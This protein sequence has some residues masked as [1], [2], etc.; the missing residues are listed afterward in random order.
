[1]KSGGFDE[2][3]HFFNVKKLHPHSHL[4]TSN[5]LIN[6]CGRVFE[7]Q[8]FFPLTKKN[9]ATLDFQKPILR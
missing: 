1:M 2:V 6:F 5:E 7:L 4:Y 3:A 8:Q 9:D